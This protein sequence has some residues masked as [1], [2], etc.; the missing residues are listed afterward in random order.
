MTDLHM[1][2]AMRRV[3]RETV[4]WL[5][6]VTLNVTRPEPAA[7]SL[8]K[9]VLA[10]TYFDITEAEIKREIAYLEERE[11]VRVERDGLGTWYNLLT[12]HGVDVVEY[13]VPVEPGIARPRKD[14]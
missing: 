9:P 6:L 7:V 13:T 2:E 4:R 14:V 10:A 3:R 8:I 12:R 11:L 1:M 5:L